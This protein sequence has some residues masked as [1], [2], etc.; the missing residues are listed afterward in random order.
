LTG[1][2]DAITIDKTAAV[3]DTGNVAIGKTVTVSG[4]SISGINAGKYSLASTTVTDT[5]DITVRTLTVSA[6]ADNKVYD[7]NTTA[8]VMLSDNRVTGDVFTVSSAFETFADENVGSGKIVTVDGISIDG[9]DV[10]NYT[11]ASTIV[12]DTADITGKTLTVSAVANNKVYDGNISATVSL[13]DNRVIDD[14]FTVSS[15]SEIFD[16]KNIGTEKIV[17]VDGISIDGA[18]AGNY[19]LASTI[20]TD[21]ADITVRMLT[22][23]ATADNKVYDGTTIA[24]VSFS[25]DRVTEDIFTVSSVSETFDTKN[26]GSG[27]TVTVEGISLNGTDAGNYTLASTTVT[28]TADITGRTLTV[29]AVADNKVYDG[30]TIATVTLSDDR[31]RGDIFTVSNVSETFDD[32]NVGSG[33]TVTVEGISI[34]GTDAGNYTLASTTATDTADITVR[35]LTVSAIADNKVYDGNATATVTLSDDRVRGDI[36]TVSNVSETFD[37]KNVGLAKTVTVEGISIDGTDAGNYTLASTTVTDTADITM[38]S[39]TISANDA[40][41]LYCTEHI[42]QGAEFNTDGLVNPDEVTSVT[43]ES[44]GAEVLASVSTYDITVSD[45]QGTGLGNY[46]IQ[47]IKGTL[48]VIENACHYQTGVTG[49]IDWSVAENWLVSLDGISNWII[50][51]E[52]PNFDNAKTV[53]IQNNTSVNLDS[54]VTIDQVTIDEGSSLTISTGSILTLAEGEGT[55]LTVKGT[56]DMNGGI[57]SLATGAAVSYGLSST[58]EYSDSAMQT[59]GVE[60]PASGVANLTINNSDSVVLD[61]NASISGGLSLLNGTFTIGAYTL[62]V[63]GN[64]TL[65]SDKTLSISTGTVDINGIF[66]ATGATITFTEA[67]NLLLGG[68]VINSGTLTSDIGTVTY[69]GAVQS[70]YAATYYNLTLGGMGEKGSFG[71]SDKEA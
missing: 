27:Q 62:D 15:V 40:D 54:D 45:A 53:I 56:L 29:S 36:F 35:T 65:S 16:D 28:D 20:V 59:P 66:D 68:T 11:L 39:L 19:T 4:L 9:T 48:T 1:F 34:D 70:V 25:D 12:T 52:P 41:K 60:F 49:D 37:D 8:T 51:A 42:F 67:G 18:D 22:V 6:T 57:L 7:G 69:D 43:L 47:Y 14:I 50:A 55:D 23:S 26:V 33:K 3:F 63:A 13:S 32:E 46:E 24:T 71:S 38:K 44:P 30:N 21:T 64:A 17:T 61:R 58:L 5:A 2:Y 31:V 10:G